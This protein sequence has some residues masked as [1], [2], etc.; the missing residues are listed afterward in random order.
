MK[1]SI[2]AIK[3]YAIHDGPNIRTTVFLKGC[4]LSCWWCHN[5]E[6]LSRDVELVYLEENCIGCRAC[7]EG[8]HTGSL[9]GVASG[10]SRNVASCNGCGDCVDCCPALAH[11]PTGQLLDVEEVMVE[12][13]KDIPFYD[14]SGGGVTFS[15]GEPLQ[16]PEFLLALLEACGGKGVHRAVDTCCHAPTATLLKIANHADLFLIDLKHM[17]NEKHQLYTGVGNRLILANITRL[18][19]NDHSVRLR[20]PLIP[21]VNDD[22]A[23]LHETGRFAS[24]ISGVEHIDVLPYHSAAKAKYAKMSRVYPGSAIAP[25]TPEVIR[26]AVTILQKYNL[27]VDIGG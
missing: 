11:E 1:G 22:S 8:C 27:Q 12:I 7:I 16:Q 5:P 15:G 25:A 24:A 9:T 13:E 3:R 21:G 19:E 14:Q 20:L 4:P 6:G 2:F 26:K 23:N 17:D 18:V 10:I